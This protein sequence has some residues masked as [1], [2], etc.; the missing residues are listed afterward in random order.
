MAR[1]H[2]YYKYG[3]RR[4]TWSMTYYPKVWFW[5]SSETLPISYNHFAGY[6]G[7]PDEK[8]SEEDLESFKEHGIPITKEEYESHIRSAKIEHQAE[9]DYEY[10]FSAK[11]GEP[12]DD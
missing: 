7:I 6:H 11:P 2:Q 5:E 8:I 4:R 12:Y 3:E 9:D 10:Y 1:H